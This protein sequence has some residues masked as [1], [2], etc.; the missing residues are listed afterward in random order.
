MEAAMSTGSGLAL[1][2]VAFLAVYR[3]G[4][5]TILF[6]QALLGSAG[7]DGAAMVA[8]GI[9]AGA[10]C[11]V[12]VYVAI[13]YFGL[14]LPLR[15]FFAVTSAALYYMAFVFAGKGIAELQAAGLVRLTPVAGAPRFPLFGIYP[16]L[17]SL[18]L[19]GLLVLLAVG[20]LVWVYLRP[21]ALGR[22]PGVTA[23]PAADR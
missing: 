7:G 14:R 19:Q 20:A 4:F 11:L 17:E 12:G 15:P 22:E 13:N 1:A 6:Y 23:R 9:G 2:A 10:V 3:E 21:S 16:T 8:A 18:V 5:E